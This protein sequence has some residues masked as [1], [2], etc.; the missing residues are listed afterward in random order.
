MARRDFSHNEITTMRNAV[1]IIMRD[2]KFAEPLSTNRED[3][4]AKLTLR[5][6]EATN[7]FDL[8][9]L[10]ALVRAELRKAQAVH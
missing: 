3:D 10:V 8:A 9:D 6:A 4:I 2:I 7:V 1:E 5:L